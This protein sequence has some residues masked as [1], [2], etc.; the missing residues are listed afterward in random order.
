M[1]A[2]L[3]GVSSAVECF[4]AGVLDSMK[5][6]HTAIFFVTSKVVRVR[7]MQCLVLNGGLFLSSVVLADYVL[8]PAFHW[9]LDVDPA[10]PL[11]ISWLPAT[12]SSLLLSVFYIVWVYPLYAI[13]FLL[14]AIW[15]QDIADMAFLTRGHKQHTPP[16]S[17]QR[18][19]AA[20]SEELYRLLLV[21][22]F[23][24]QLSLVS[25]LPVV[26]Q[27]LSVLHLCWLYSLYSFE[28][29]WSLQ[30]WRLE[31]RLDFFERRWSY[32]AGFGCPAALLGVLFP[33]LIASGVFAMAFPMF[34]ILAVIAKPLPL[35]QTYSTS[36]GHNSL[37]GSDMLSASSAA[38]SF[39][40]PIFQFAKRA[41]LALLKQI[42]QTA[43]TA[44]SHRAAH[45]ANS[46]AATT[47]STRP[48]AQ[49]PAFPSATDSPRPP[50]PHQ[51]AERL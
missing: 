13:S 20:M 34:I 43:P 47:A 4:A 3:L 21:S 45:T 39:R 11:S 10:T 29:K 48:S 46:G 27:P 42:Q 17:F 26:G 38:A 9:L 5:F 25:L 35:P 18:W 15:Y 44:S 32:F 23:L 1:S 6:P 19:I 33:R 14:N 37:R 12:L 24:V 51:P 7:F 49:W 31:T 16:L 28:Y 41:N 22:L 2:V 8:T 40:L 36:S 50:P 30:G